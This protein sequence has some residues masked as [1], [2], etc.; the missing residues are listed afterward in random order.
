MTTTHVHTF[1][2]IRNSYKI[3]V[4]YYALKKNPLKRINKSD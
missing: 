1:T 2:E 3:Y 4:D